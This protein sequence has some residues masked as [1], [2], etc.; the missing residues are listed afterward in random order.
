MPIIER[1][2]KQPADVQDYDIDFSPYLVGHGGDTV[3]SY[4]VE[5]DPGIV[6]QSHT[7]A[8]GVVKVWLAGGMSK[9]AYKVTIRITTN[10][11]R[12]HEVEILVTVVED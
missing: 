1:F 5:A 4:Q 7:H 6:V 9:N 3:A 2:R 11:G 10:G 12:V 8:D